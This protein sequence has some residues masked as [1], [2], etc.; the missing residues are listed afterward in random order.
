MGHYDKQ[1]EE[2]ILAASISIRN[3]AKQDVEHISNEQQAEDYI[4][5][6]KSEYIAGFKT[7]EELLQSI[8]EHKAHIDL[9]DNPWNPVNTEVDAKPQLKETQGKAKDARYC[10]LGDIA[11]V[12]FDHP[13]M[14]DAVYDQLLLL[15]EHLSIIVESID[16]D[17]LENAQYYCSEIL[18]N[19]MQDGDMIHE[20][21]K[22]RAQALNSGKYTVEGYRHTIDI[23]L[24]LD[25]AARH[26]L[27]IVFVGDID[28]ESECKHLAHIAAN[29][30]M[31]HTQ[32]ELNQ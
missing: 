25:A 16:D 27:Q 10:Y 4:N 14:S 6:M 28:K 21:V 2:A 18:N 8:D 31:I 30:I 20:L 17:N 26:F 13:V 9:L 22:V 5:R 12:A 11:R 3:E 24:L 19:V 29:M 15:G 32:M 7:E 23:T 1:F